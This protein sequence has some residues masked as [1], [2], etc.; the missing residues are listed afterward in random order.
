MLQICSGLTLC[1]MNSVD[2]SYVGITEKRKG[3]KKT[4]IKYRT[5]IINKYNYIIQAGKRKKITL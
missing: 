1:T 2:N 5:F 3:K 4:N